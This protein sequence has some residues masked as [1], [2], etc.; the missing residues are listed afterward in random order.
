MRNS[1]FLGG[2]DISSID[3]NTQKREH[4][5]IDLFAGCGG[6]SLGLESAGFEGLAAVE[7]EPHAVRTYRRNFNHPVIDGD[8][9]LQKTKERIYNNVGGEELDVLTGGFPCQGFSTSG[10]R[11]IEDPRNRLFKEFV[12]IASVLK[13]KV[14]IGE[15]VTGILT[16]GGKGKMVREI[17]SA[18]NSIGYDM[19]VQ[20]LNAADYGVA[21]TRE[22]VIFVGNR[23]GAQNLF[24]MPILSPSN[25]VTAWGAISDLESCE[26]DFGFNHEFAVHSPMMIQ[27]LNS[28]PAGANLYA[29]RKDAWRRLEKD[30]PSFTV[31]DCHG[32][33]AVHPT[34]PRTIT[35]RE[36]ARLQSFPDT[37]IF[38][39]AKKYQQRQVGNAVPPLLGKAIG[40]AVRKMLAD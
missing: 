16:M 37:F 13:P 39:G 35:V 4:T 18:F 23:I 12:E 27:R 40:L 30:K 5:F 9:R 6:L 2:T 36:M 32:A 15:N 29:K 34:L 10:L 19:D 38:A 1:M 22:R 28:L 25:Y 33:C 21:Q 3:T 17:I 14:V 7:V 24:P 20:V 8:I 26:E 31:K 11:M